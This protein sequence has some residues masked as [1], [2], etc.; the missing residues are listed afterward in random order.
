MADIQL[1]TNE[2]ASRWRKS[3]DRSNDAFF[4]ITKGVVTGS[5]ITNPSDVERITKQIRIKLRER[6]ANARHSRAARKVVRGFNAT[7]AS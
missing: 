1:L 2:A 5:G 7:H 4:R 3:T 6:S